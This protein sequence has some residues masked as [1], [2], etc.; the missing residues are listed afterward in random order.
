MRHSGED[1][2][3]AGSRHVG[4]RRD[5]R[6]ADNV[7]P[8]PTRR[9]RRGLGARIAAVPEP[10]API[11]PGPAAGL[12][13]GAWAGV[14]SLLLVA[15]IVIVAWIF[16]PLGSG[17]FSDALRVAGVVW[18]I[19]D[20]GAVTWT[21][22]VLSLPPLLVTAGVV[23]FQRRA[24]RWLVDAVAARTAAAVAPGIAFAIVAAASVQVLVSTSVET[25]GVV[26]PLWRNI[27]GALVVGTI[28][29]G[30]GAIS[31]LR[32][33]WPPLLARAGR[34]LIVTFAGLLGSA[35]LVVAV[36]GVAQRSAFAG[37]L[38]AVAGDGTSVLQVLVVCLAYLPT[39][40][41]WAMA[42]ILGP[43]FIV[44]TG[45]SVSLGSTVVGALPPVPLFALLPLDMPPIARWLIAV[46]LLAGLAGALRL[47]SDRS[48]AL[49]AVH[50]L[51]AVAVGGLL[52]LASTGGIGPGRLTVTGP[53]WWHVALAIGGWTLAAVLAD[54]V[55]HRAAGWWQGRGAGTAEPAE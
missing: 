23:L 35:A 34:S 13:A 49:R 46:P 38:T 15:F 8:L 31:E 40:V 42:T 30:S 7:V 6:A 53:I 44:G 47:R 48:L 11:W 41:L 18:L 51:G 25:D 52:A 12:I 14:M 55:A 16:A 45:T 17:A 32:P 9:A 26:A 33:A 19:G 29:F 5:G 10:G 2:S 39:M 1:A 24:A 37:V 36:V 50:V 27:V 22:A 20:G 3:S 21:G 54:E 28:G 4:D 43:G